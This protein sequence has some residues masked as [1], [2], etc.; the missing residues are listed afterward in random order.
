M[1]MQRF[2]RRAFLAAAIMVAGVFA[3]PAQLLLFGAPRGEAASFTSGNMQIRAE[4]FRACTPCPG[5]AVVLLHGS[6]GMTK[7]ASTYRM[8]ANQLASAGITTVVVRYFDRTCTPPDAPN[9]ATDPVQF[10]AWVATVKDAIRFTGSLPEVDSRRIGIVGFSLGAFVGVAA[11]ANNPHVKALVEVSGGVA[12]PVAGKVKHMP[13]TLVV[14]G[15][16]DAIVPVTEAEKLAAVLRKVGARHE[17]RIYPCEEHILKGAAQKDA[18]ER[19]LNF[20][21]GNL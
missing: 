1:T 12:A 21:L 2:T 11:S 13:A 4:I 6:D 20:L 19:G 14:H 7:Y 9:L 10:N 15:G 16:C 5:P 17:V 18:S 3:A 8:A